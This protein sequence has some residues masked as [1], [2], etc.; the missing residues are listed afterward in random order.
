MLSKILSIFQ[1][2][3]RPLLMAQKI[4]VVTLGTFMAAAMTWTI[5]SRLVFKNS[6]LGLEEIVLISAIWFYMIGAALAASE[7]SHLRV[8]IVPMVIKN[9]KVLATIQLAI[10]FIVLLAAG[11]IAYLSFDL[12]GWAIEKKTALPATRIPA[13]VPQ[14]AFALST[15]LFL[16]YFARD[17]VSD[18]KAWLEALAF[19]GKAGPRAAIEGEAGEGAGDGPERSASGGT[20]KP[21]ETGG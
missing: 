18:L 3:N 21:S 20:T 16:L 9:I 14:S 12:L 7:R 19:G 13:A 10:S 6:L 15:T 5:F 2:A 8:E 17:L 1:A 11:V 4:M